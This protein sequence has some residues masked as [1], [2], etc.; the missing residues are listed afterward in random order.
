MSTRSIPTMECL[1]LTLFDLKNSLPLNDDLPRFL[2]HFIASSPPVIKG[3]ITK[4]YKSKTNVNNTYVLHEL[5][6][7]VCKWINTL[8]QYEEESAPSNQVNL[9]ICIPVKLLQCT[10]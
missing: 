10:V 4:P 1:L 5:S 9:Y 6:L 3:L 2:L 7:S 8:K